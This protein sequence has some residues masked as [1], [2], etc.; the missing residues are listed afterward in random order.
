MVGS[1]AETRQSPRGK[2]TCAVRTYLDG[3]RGEPLVAQP[4]ADLAG[5]ALHQRRGAHHQHLFDVRALRTLLQQRP[6]ERYA[7]QRLAQAL[8]PRR[9]ERRCRLGTFNPYPSPSGEPVGMRVGVI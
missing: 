4:L 2:T 3:A 6:D 7:L 5:P 1:I 9:S 8:Q